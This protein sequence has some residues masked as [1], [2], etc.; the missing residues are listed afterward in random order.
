M[1]YDCPVTWKCSNCKKLYDSS[2]KKLKKKIRGIITHIIICP[3]CNYEQRKGD[4]VRDGLLE[5][6]K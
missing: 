4:F 1:I 6:K 3:Y 5:A 2:N